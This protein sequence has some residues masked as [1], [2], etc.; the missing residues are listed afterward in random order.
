MV[1]EWLVYSGFILRRSTLFPFITGFL[2]AETGVAVAEESSG[3]IIG[4]EGR[5]F[6]CYEETGEF[7]MSGLLD[8]A[9]TGTHQV[10]M[11]GGL[12]FIERLVC[13][14]QMATQYAA[15]TQQL[16]RIVDRTPRD[17]IMS[18]F[19]SLQKVMDSEMPLHSQGLAQYGEPFRRL[20]AGMGP[21]I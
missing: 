5:I 3:E 1:L 15:V 20:T 16:H 8:L 21:Q 11:I 19:H 2:L 10:E 17:M 9:T 12:T 7:R 4:L 18:P 6:H 13:V 14:K